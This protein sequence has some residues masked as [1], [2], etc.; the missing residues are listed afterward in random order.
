MKPLK[1]YNP[2][3][4]VNPNAWLK[5]CALTASTKEV[6]WHGYATKADDMYYIKDIVVFPQVV[7][8]TTVEPDEKEYYE[9]LNEQW[10]NDPVAASEIRFHGHSHVKMN[11]TP[12]GVDNTYRKNLISNLKEDDFY[13]FLIMNQAG[14]YTIQI[15]DTQYMIIFD[16][17][18]IEFII[19]TPSDAAI[20]QDWAKAE[21]AKY[22]TENKYTQSYGG[23]N[24]CQKYS[25]TANPSKYGT[26]EH[27][28][29]NQY[30][31]LDAEQLEELYRN[32]YVD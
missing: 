5:M 7:T 9:W 15:Y 21:H 23:K 25:T 16:T 11:T 14:E 6:G 20:A 31:S 32:C 28:V 17:N 19:G 27:Y 30:T 10:D 3:V 13:I 4:F 24:K 26:L 29:E 1:T 8:G 22:V 2:T 18:D 12:S